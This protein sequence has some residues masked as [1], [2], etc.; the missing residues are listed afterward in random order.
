MTNTN[1][2]PQHGPTFSKQSGGITDFE[3]GFLSRKWFDYGKIL[4]L[5]GKTRKKDLIKILLVAAAVASL[6][7]RRF[8]YP[9]VEL[10]VGDCDKT[11]SGLYISK[12]QLIFIKKFDPEKVWQIIN[13]YQNEHLANELSILGFDKEDIGLILNR[14]QSGYRLIKILPEYENNENDQNNI[15]DTALGFKLLFEKKLVSPDQY[16][17][18]ITIYR[19]VTYFYNHFY[20]ALKQPALSQAEK[21]QIKEEMETEMM[22]V[23]IDA[24]LLNSVFEKFDSL[25]EQFSTESG[26]ILS[27][28]PTNVIHYAEQKLSSRDYIYSLENHLIEQS[29]RMKLNGLS[30]N[31]FKD[32]AVEFFEHDSSVFYKQN[33]DTL[34]KN[35]F[36]VLRKYD[37]VFNQAWLQKL[38][39]ALLVPAWKAYKIEVSSLESQIIFNILPPMTEELRIQFI[40]FVKE[41]TQ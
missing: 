41:N 37:P 30:Y 1:T 40:N 22:E 38:A 35:I 4:L 16:F 7:N 10:P 11:G 2:L 3:P 9:G 13:S 31:F 28:E 15:Q 32:L 17:E 21:F 34:T 19:I 6:R 20:Q 25:T 29:L 36:S 14:K 12:S 18:V 8:F 26:L 33:E 5:V 24:D 23:G 27:S 39:R